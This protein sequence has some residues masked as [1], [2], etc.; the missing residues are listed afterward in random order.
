MYGRP[1]YITRKEDGSSG[2]Y[3]IRNG[4]FGVCSRRIHLKE[5]ETNG[6][7]K[8]ARKYD[9]ENVLK[10][11]FPD[12]EIA[13]QGEVIGPGIQNNKLGLKELEFRLFN[14][15]DINSRSYFDYTRIVDFTKKYNI[16]MVP[17]VN[18]GTTFGYS[19][20]ELVELAKAQDYPTGGPAEGIV[21]R[22][23][24]PFY[25]NVLK[26]SW[27]GKVINDRYDGD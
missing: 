23:K 20:E 9:I 2:T 24:D 11:A 26:K 15:F 21:I 19:L 17:V 22:P 7:W 14:V 8:M 10:S 1:F 5:S 18:E 16:P 13:I 12:K 6:F 27:S 4:T 25:S 3:F